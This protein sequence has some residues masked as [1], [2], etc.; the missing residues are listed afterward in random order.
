MER[1]R[2][3][4]IGYRKSW[5]TN[6]K[7][8]NVLTDVFGV[9]GQLMLDALWKGE[10][11]PEEIAQFARKRAKRKIPEI[12]AAWEG[13]QMN[14]HHRKMIRYSLS[15][16]K[17]IEEQIEKI[18]RDIAA[19]IQEA[20]LDR[21]WQILQTVPGVQPRSAAKIFAETGADMTQ[22]PS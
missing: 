16:R 9:S 17:F 20:G 21:P 14:E 10:A 12:I 1:A 4:R 19:K 8:G 13:Q 5:K 18:D 11:K 15:H 3:K 2:P 22:F 6:V 7:L